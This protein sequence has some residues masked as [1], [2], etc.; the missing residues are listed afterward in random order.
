MFADVGMAVERCSGREDAYFK[1]HVDLYKY[2]IW[3]VND[4]CLFSWFLCLYHPY[5][6]QT[7]YS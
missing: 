1:R 5:I 3:M 2:G 7:F 6:P 4:L